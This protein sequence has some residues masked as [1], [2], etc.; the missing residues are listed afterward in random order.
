MYY[1]YSTIVTV[2]RGARPSQRRRPKNKKR[3]KALPLLMTAEDKVFVGYGDYPNMNRHV[4]NEQ[5]VQLQALTEIQS[6]L[7]GSA[8]VPT[9]A[10]QAFTVGGLTGGIANA[11]GVFDQYRIDLIEVWLISRDP[12]GVNAGNPGLLTSVVDLDDNTTP[13]SLSTLQSYSSA[14]T[15]SGAACHYHRWVPHVADDLYTGTFSGFGNMQ[16]RW[17]DS[18]STGVQH[19]ALKCGVTANT[20]ISYD[21]VTRFTVSF[22]GLF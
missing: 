16:D 7:A 13:S 18:A 6:F 4:S 9:Y 2:T 5:Q 21:L 8:S 14:L 17:I 22:R 12:T 3:S 19:Y 11:L 15:T 10:S 20:A 1:S